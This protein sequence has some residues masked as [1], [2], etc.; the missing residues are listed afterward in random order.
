MGLK[1][2]FFYTPLGRRRLIFSSKS[3]GGSWFRH[4]LAPP[5]W[6]YDLYSHGP[7]IHIQAP[8]KT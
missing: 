8:Q 2:Q 3:P 5:K 7:P 1:D 4:D 6:G